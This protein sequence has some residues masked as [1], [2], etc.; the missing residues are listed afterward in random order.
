YVGDGNNICHSLMRLSS[1]LGTSI[2]VATPE[3]YEPNQQI[4]ETVHEEADKTGA[5]ILVTNDPSEAVSGANA[6]Y[7][8]VWASMGQEE[9]ADDRAGVFQP[10]QVNAALMSK[11]AEGAYAMHDLPAH[12]GEEI[13][14]DVMD[15]PNSLCFDQ[16]ENRL[17][18]QKAILVMLDEWRD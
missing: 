5:K 6:V 11:A 1:R 8:D 17:H 7:T 12:R 9:E 2:R 14:D 16:A 15:G 10:F 4:L 3:G 18:A 13:T